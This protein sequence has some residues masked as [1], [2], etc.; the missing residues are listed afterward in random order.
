MAI[1]QP[2]KGYRPTPQRA[3]LVSSPPYDVMSSDEARKISSGNS[4]SFLRIIKPEID[5]TSGN[6]PK[7]DD[8]HLHGKSN[9][10]SFIENGNLIQDESPCLYLYQIQ[11]GEHIQTGVVAG[12]SIDEYNTGTIKKHEFTRPDKENDRTRHIYITNANTGPV[13]LTFRN[14]NNFK[15]TVE[16]MVCAAPETSFTSEDNT[17]HTLWKINHPQQIKKLKQFFESVADL[18]IADGHHRAASASRVQKLKKETNQSHNGKEAY[19]FFLSV[20]FPNDEVQILDYNRV[21]KDLNG[22]NTE[23]FLEHVQQNFSLSP[24]SD[25]PSPLPAYKIAM[26]LNCQWYLLTPNNNILSDDPV[27]GLDA[28]ILQSHLLSPVLGIDDPR[29]NYR[30]DFVGG[31][32]GMRELERRC[33]SDCMVAFALPPIKIE[34][35]LSVADSGKV[36]PPKSTW[37][38]PKLRSGMVVRML[39]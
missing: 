3:A 29:T 13:F 4:D 38:E 25:L 23:Q 27:D 19:N 26:L 16:D 1:I 21:V 39:E 18:Y 11:M 12:V 31:I 28:A 33:Q 35:L 10:D 8:L 17:I 32:R 36:M 14:S 20:I 30:I 7:G 6:E 24:V 5:F 37:F 2:F 34:Q 9:L 15:L 22:L